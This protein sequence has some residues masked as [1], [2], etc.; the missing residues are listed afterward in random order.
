M[1]KDQVALVDGLRLFALGA[2]LVGLAATPG[3]PEAF[4]EEARTPEVIK[5]VS[6]HLYVYWAPVLGSWVAQCEQLYTRPWTY[7]AEGKGYA[8]ALHQGLAHLYSHPRAKDGSARISASVHSPGDAV[9]R[10]NGRVRNLTAGCYT[11]ASKEC[12]YAFHYDGNGT[13]TGP[14]HVDG[15]RSYPR[16]QTGWQI[17]E[18]DADCARSILGDL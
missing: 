12:G 18:S 14:H 6:P 3:G 1:S 4:A 10:T 11:C 16:K 15:S 5:A 7:V 17:M 9:T 13:W 2:G 8:Q